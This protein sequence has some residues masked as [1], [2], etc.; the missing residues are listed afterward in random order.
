MEILEDGKVIYAELEFMEK[1]LSM[2]KEVRKK[3]G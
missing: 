2:L 3:M 1:A